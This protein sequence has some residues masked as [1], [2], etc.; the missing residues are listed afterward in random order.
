[1][2]RQLRVQPN[3]A[4][5]LALASLRFI[6]DFAMLVATLTHALSVTEWA[7]LGTTVGLSDK[8]L[9]GYPEI[10]VRR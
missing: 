3:P 5:T 10:T 9:T 2:V 6:I 7:L 4:L 8:V 1:M